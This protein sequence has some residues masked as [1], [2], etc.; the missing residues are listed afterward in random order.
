VFTPSEREVAWAR[1]VVD[2]FDAAGGDALRLADGEF[3]DL[4]VAERARRLLEL[5]AGLSTVV[6]GA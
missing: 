1:Q 6:G 4:P 3:V 2:A 5:A